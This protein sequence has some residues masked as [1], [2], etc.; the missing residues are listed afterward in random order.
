MAEN[1][2][3]QINPDSMNQQQALNV[4]VQ[5]A[6]IAQAKGAYTLED[7]ELVAKAIKVFIPT[8]DP[9]AVINKDAEPA[10]EEAPKAEA[11]TK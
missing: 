9:N 7:A 8:Q 4:L 1:N 6:R 11:P 3:N 10:A 2:A 5:A